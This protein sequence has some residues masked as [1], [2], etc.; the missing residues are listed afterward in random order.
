MHKHLVCDQQGRV[1]LLCNTQQ[2]YQH[3]LEISSQDA[4]V[5]VQGI[6]FQHYSPSVANNYALFVF[7]SEL[8]IQLE[9]KIESVLILL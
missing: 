9:L 6:A 7:V 4:Q 2:P 1:E 5:V 3:C 8:N